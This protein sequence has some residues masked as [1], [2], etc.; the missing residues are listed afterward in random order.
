[1]SIDLRKPVSASNLAAGTFLSVHAMK[2]G[3]HTWFNSNDART[4]PFI[5]AH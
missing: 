3:Q 1:M 4:A 5:Y 2:D